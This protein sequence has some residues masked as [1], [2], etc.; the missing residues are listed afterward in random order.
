MVSVAEVPCAHKH[1]WEAL[2]VG[3]LDP[4][5]PTALQGD[6]DRDPVV[7]GTCTQPALAGYLGPNGAGTFNLKTLPPTP[8]D[9]AAGRKGFWCLAA[10]PGAGLVTGS[11]KDQ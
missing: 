1:F 5:T 6:V 2:A 9:F 7:A 11:L 10:R 3:V 4:G 8:A